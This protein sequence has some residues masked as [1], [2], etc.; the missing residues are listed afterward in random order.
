MDGQLQL[1]LGAGSRAALTV[2]QLVRTVREALEANLDE[3]WVAGEVSN[4]HLAG[5]GHCYFTLKDAASAIRVVMFK[6]AYRRVRFRLEDGMEVLVRGRVSLYEAR[7]DLQFY[8]EELEPRG[9]GALQI[10][11][12]QLKR[13][14]ASEGLFDPA[15]KRELPFLPRVVGIVTARG[16]AGLRDILRILFDRFPNLHVIVRPALVQGAAA[17]GEIVAAIEDLNADGRAEAIIV[18]RGGGSLEDLWAFNE[19][20]V[21]RAIYRS[22]IPIVSAVGHE[23]DFTIADFVADQRAPT[24]TAAAQMVVPERTEL[25]RRIQRTR[26]ELA[27]AMAAVIDGHRRELAHLRAR[28]RD[29]RTVIRQ[30]RQ[31]AD[32]AAADLAAAIARRIAAAR[33]RVA[34][35]RAGM[36]SPAAPLRERRLIANRFAERLAAGVAA[37]LAASRNRLGGAARRLDDVSPLRVLERGYAVVKNPRTGR[38]LTAAAQAEIGDELEIMLSRGRLRARTFAREI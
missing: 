35:L 26:A 38:A 27:G 4:A 13:R 37:A 16:G 28:I 7:G 23:V 14:L 32:D 36:R 18:G 10:A 9:A 24:P 2:T 11:F 8:A 6:S 33:A 21:A 34:E 31:R 19:E 30:T 5:S 22:R 3:Y 15:H 25:R 12:E 1:T 20:A 17:A 29:P